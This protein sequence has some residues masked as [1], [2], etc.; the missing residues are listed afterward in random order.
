MTSKK[1]VGLVVG[2][3]ILS[4]LLPVMLSVWF[5]HYQAEKEFTRDLNDYGE[6][7]IF[8]VQ[9]VVGEAKDTL[10][11]IDT[12]QG[13][14][15]SEGHLR[16]MRLASYTHR[17]VQEVLSLK[18]L[19]PMCSS[20][21]N[22][23][24]DITFPPTDRRTV[25]GYRVW[26]TDAN[27]LGIK[28]E[29]VALASD[30]HMVM[31]DPGSFI[32]VVPYASWAIH[33]ALIGS[34]SGSL[35]AQSAPFDL[36]LWQQE[37]HIGNHTVAR[38]GVL[39]NF[40]DYPDIGISQVV[41]ASAAPLTAK[42]HQQLFLW[43]P[44]G[45][46]MSLIGTWLILRMVRNLQSPYHRMLDAIN[47]RSLD[48]YYQPIV[49]LRSGK[50]VGA[51][52][53]ARWRQPD[54]TFLSPEIFVPMAEQTGLITRLTQLIVEK[55]FEDL[56][57]WLKLHPEQHVSI[58]LD[59]QDL[60]S[61]ALP[62]QLAQQ[63]NKWAIS[64]S[65]VALELTERSFIDLKNSASTLSQLRRAGYALYID[66]FGTGYSSLSYLQN[67]D[68]DIIKIDKAFVDALELNNVTPHII[69]MAKT[70]KL[71]MVAEG[72]ETECQRKW[73]AE[74]GVQFGQGWLFSKALPKAAFILWAEANLHES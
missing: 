68:V 53:L 60:I 37:R 11:D 13:E 74:H 57:A 49:S 47:A 71:A 21:E 24:R 45:V 51:E 56:G 5:A 17:E 12:Y 58:N 54:G 18:S 52:A 46:I 25:D 28:R 6:R 31:L 34:Q 14:P 69:D 64:P 72:V 30:R 61:T 19:K 38:N 63:L 36:R 4:V 7:V 70:L 62:S 41:W 44:L 35:I 39:Y 9:Q 22:Q 73:L 67:L 15:C 2:V 20:L 1:M 3:L 55:V 40:R 8:R 29:M 42:W 32:D 26:L 43:L 59:P 27:D 23:S 16:A 48:V 33:T 50:I 65:Q 10:K 66:D